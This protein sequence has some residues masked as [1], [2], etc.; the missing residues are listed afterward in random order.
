M[1]LKRILSLA[2]SG[3]LAVSMLTACG[4]GGG[5]GLSGNSIKGDTTAVRK[6][7][8]AELDTLA[9]TTV[10]YKTDGD[11]T[12]A[13]AAVARTLT[14]AE[15]KAATKDGAI[16]SGTAS[17][18]MSRYV[19]YDRWTSSFGTYHPTTPEKLTYVTALV[20]DG[21]MTA[22]EV[23]EAMAANVAKWELNTA[24]TKFN[25]FDGSVA[26]YKV[27]IEATGDEA[28]DISVWFVG[29]ML[30]QTPVQSSTAA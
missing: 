20:F 1:K 26:A 8:N 7:M 24:D 2:L 27:T 19:E 12:D 17:N 6:A 16:V 4:I 23:G 5:A 21:S 25:S 10:D 9:Q 30:E 18:M 28:K 14:E 13:T 29:L 3:V 22:Q 11:L 15:A